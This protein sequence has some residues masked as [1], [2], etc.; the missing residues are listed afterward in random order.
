MGLSLTS[1]EVKRALEHPELQGKKP[2]GRG[3]YS[4]VFDN[5]DAVLKLTVDRG[6][7]D[8]QAYLE[9][10]CQSLHTLPKI[11]RVV[12]EIG[13]CAG[14]PLWLLEVERLDK[15]VAGT[16]QRKQALRLKKIQHGINGKAIAESY[17]R[18]A[19][20][21]C[22]HMS[23]SS[24]IDEQWSNTFRLLADYAAGKHH[25]GCD[26]HPGNFLTRPATGELVLNDPFEDRTH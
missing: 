25:L 23:V 4:L 21:T 9:N 10:A 19:E 8:L 24:E 11:R 12:G 14:Q 17:F 2:F 15:L 13:E 22:R 1:K 18:V 6:A 16:P 7:V 5:A 26:F 20:L 3:R